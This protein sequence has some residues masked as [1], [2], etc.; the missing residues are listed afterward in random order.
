M[1]STSGEGVRMNDR[2][3]KIAQILFDINSYYQRL[4]VGVS[5]NVSEIALCEGQLRDHQW[6]GRRFLESLPP[7]EQIRRSRWGGNEIV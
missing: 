7:D 5:V 4:R 3:Y 1:I 6:P 2:I